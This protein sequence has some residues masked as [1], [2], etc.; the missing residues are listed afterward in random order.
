MGYRPSENGSFVA[1][2]KLAES[3]N[4]ISSLNSV[5]SL[6]T[7]GPKLHEALPVCDTISLTCASDVRGSESDKIEPKRIEITARKP[8]SSLS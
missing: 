4:T 5:F 8:V 6:D 7:S 1:A 2:R 3:Y